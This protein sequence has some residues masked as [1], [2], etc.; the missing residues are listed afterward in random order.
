MT[1][2]TVPKREEVSAMNQAIF[3]QLRS[4]LGMVPNLF[5]T[6]AYSETALENYMALQSGKT[7]LSMKEKEAINLVVS[8][9]NTCRYCLSAHTLL[10]KMNGL[11]EAQ[12]LEI[13]KGKADFDPKLDALVRFAKEATVNK[14]KV[15]DAALTR[16]YNA[17]YSK[18]TIVDVILAIADKSVANYLHNLTD[19]PIDFPLA[20][21]VEKETAE[22]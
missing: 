13:R 6:M 8:E 16:F 19:I 12:M 18:G 9:V 2:F 22:V 1:Q 11:S 15:S 10:G 20:I 5:A 17:G 7:S 14:G 21:P 4:M 3:D